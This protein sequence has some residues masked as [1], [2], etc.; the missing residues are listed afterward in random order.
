[1]ELITGALL[2]S[3]LCDVWLRYGTTSP[4]CSR[5]GW[6]SSTISSGDDSTCTVVTACNADKAKGAPPVPLPP[7]TKPGKFILNVACE[8]LATDVCSALLRTPL[9]PPDLK[10]NCVPY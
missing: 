9:I 8:K 1:M 6:L 2:T 10:K 4:T 7:S 5:A 3:V